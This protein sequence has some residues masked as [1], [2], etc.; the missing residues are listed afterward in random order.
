MKCAVVIP[1]YN[2][3]PTLEGVLQGVLA[4]TADV[5]VVNDGSSDRTCS[6]LDR[7][8][9]KARI[10]HPVNL[11]KG[12]AL[13]TGFNKAREMGYTHVISM[14]SDGQHQSS[15]LRAFLHEM[16][17]HPD[18][19]IVGERDLRG[20]GRPL[21]SRILRL[22]SNFWVLMETGKWV[23]DSQSGFRG[24]P[25]KPL[26]EIELQCSKY[27]FEIEILVKTLWMGVEVRSIP[28]AVRYGTGS[29]SHFRPFHDFW[30]VTRLNLRLLGERF[31]PLRLRKKRMRQ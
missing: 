24:Y 15:D 5:I 27:D 10:D 29:H 1:S 13:Q 3:D 20:T 21:K 6:L 4:E 26:E 22:N 16:Q 18:D 7:F 31:L 12:A 9:L 23:S 25:L 30:L 14:D 28:I 11:G 17:A 2:N 8:P 19:L